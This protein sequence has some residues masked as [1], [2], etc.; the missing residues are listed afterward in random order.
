MGSGPQDLHALTVF[1]DDSY[2]LEDCN[3]MKCE[4][5]HIL[6]NCAEYFVDSG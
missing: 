6:F 4:H 2:M 3:D 5:L 1:Y